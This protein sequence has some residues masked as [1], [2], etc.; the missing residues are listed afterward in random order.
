M[1]RRL[2][3]VPRAALA[4]LGLAVL[5]A[6]ATGAPELPR[7]A[8][9]APAAAPSGRVT[10]VPAGGSL[11]AALDRATPGD[12]IALEAGATY[13]GPFTLPRKSGEGFIVVRS[14]AP[15][16]ELPP[17]GHRVD[18][19]HA[20]LMPKLVSASGSV[21]AAAPGANHYR[22]VGVEIAPRDGVFLK[23][24]VDLGAGASSLESVPH[25]LVFE[26]CYVHGDRV[27][28]A[29][30]GI[31][32]NARDV[33]V[34]DSYFADFKEVGADSQAIAGWNGPGPFAL[35]NNY[36]E[37]AGENVLFGGADPTIKDLVPSDIEIRRN[38]LAKP[39]AWKAGEPGYEGKTW[40]VKNLLELK[41]ARRVLIDG[42]LL[43]GNWRDSQ[44]GFAV[45]F[46]VRNQDGGAPWS[47]VEDVTFQNNVVRHTGA[48]INI[49]GRD[50][51][52]QSA[53]A[54]RIAIRN[55]L[56]ADVGGPRWGGTGALLQILNGAAQVVVEHNTALQTGSILVAEGT[57]NEGFVFRANVLPH[58]EYGMIGTGT[59]PGT[60]T[61][62]RFFP[63]AVIEGNVIA[64]GD[65]ARYPRGNHFPASLSAVGFTDRE[66]GDYRL[67]EGSRYR[68]GA[69][70][71]DAGV[72]MAA[73]TAA[74]ALKT[75]ERPTR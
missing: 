51:I 75:E 45:L 13:T 50:D 40:S 25:H 69:A 6:A 65:A 61:I 5:G 58:N 39:L 8:V 41:N 28:G 11:Q 47:T 66:R 4:A 12:V 53:P 59:A 49:L 9:E 21:I 36:L 27:R 44:N 17:P 3:R 34:V 46:T 26:R 57:P 16:A 56:F 70:G 60:A 14:G 24:L 32:M 35:V 1:S 42:N 67:A 71:R 23:N 2:R 73:L 63:G 22:F 18:P 55:N 52:R 54:R 38:H 7:A 10:A 74:G 43:E 68:N 33:L 15:E 29:R 19:S 62:A 64:G 72:D 30:R 37:A 31:A 48:G 20:H